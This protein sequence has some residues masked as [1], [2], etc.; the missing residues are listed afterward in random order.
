MA[1]SAPVQI[2]VL[3][4]LWTRSVRQVMDTS[5]INGPDKLVNRHGAML[6]LAATAMAMAF[7][8]KFF[9]DGSTVGDSAEKF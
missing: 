3:G 4:G 2:R 6:A 1:H 7:K 8:G 9:R 5:T